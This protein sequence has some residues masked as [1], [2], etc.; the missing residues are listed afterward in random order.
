MEKYQ[1]FEP[2]DLAF[3]RNAEKPNK[4][5]DEKLVSDYLNEISQRLI[6]FEDGKKLSLGEGLALKFFK[7][8][9]EHPTAKN[10][11][12]YAKLTGMTVDKVDVNVNNVA[13]ML[14]STKSDEQTK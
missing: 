11:E 4:K 3:A 12:T 7:E 14:M 13:A 6:T 2:E 8:V 10:M 5:L 1:F 9:W